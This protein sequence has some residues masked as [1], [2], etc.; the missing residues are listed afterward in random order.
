MKNSKRWISVAAVLFLAAAATTGW[1]FF[2]QVRWGVV[3]GTLVDEM[4]QGPVWH[5]AIVV[6]G[7]STYTFS[8]TDFRLSKISPGDYTLKVSAP[9]YL[10]FTKPVTVRPGQNVLHLAVKGSGIPGLKGIL[11]FGEALEKGLRVEIRLTDSDGVA[12]T[13]HPAIECRLKVALYLRE[14]IEPNYTKGMQLFEGPLD[15]FWDKEDSLARYKGIIPWDKM[16]IRPKPNQIGMLEATLITSQGTFTFT[17][18]EIEF[19][20]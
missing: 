6:D 19:S 18:N 1:F 7:R 11:A 2:K 16:K 13:H 5:A 10:D 17:I 12:I 9:N 8:S 4:S 20:Q 14:G 15:L 3:E